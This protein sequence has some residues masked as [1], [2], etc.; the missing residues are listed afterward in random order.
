M[1][2]KIIETV[3]NEKVSVGFSFSPVKKKRAMWGLEFF[4]GRACTRAGHARAHA[5]RAA[6]RGSR[7]HTVRRHPGGTA[8]R[9]APAPQLMLRT[10]S[11]R[12]SVL[13]R[14]RPTSS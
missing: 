11:D 8:G 5:L 14:I 10:D 1:C 9:L 12:A 2:F 13:T 7:T 3:E 4:L 6:D